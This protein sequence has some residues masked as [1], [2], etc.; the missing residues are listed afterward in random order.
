MR[1]IYFLLFGLF[2]SFFFDPV[3]KAQTA[4]VYTFSVSTGALDPMTGSTILI[5][6]GTDDAT[7]FL[8]DIGFTF[9][10]ENIGYTQFSVSPDGFLKLGSSAAVPQITNNITTATNV[11]KLFLFWDDIATGNNGSVRSLISG[12]APNRI[13]IV[14]W[15]VTIPRNTTGAANSTMQ[16]WLY[17]SSGKIEFRYGAG[18]GPASSA[19]IGISGVVSTNYISVTTPAN[20]ASTS[21]ANNSN[22]LWPGSGV[23]YTFSP[24]GPCTG[25]P[26]GGTTV[27]PSGTVCPGIN[28]L[29]VTGSTFGAGLTYQWESSIDNI[30]WSPIAGE[31]NQSLT[32]IIT[33]DTY[34][35]RRIIC[36]AEEAYSS[37]LLV[38]VS[39]SVLTLPIS[40]GFNT[41]GTAIFPNCWTQQYVIGTSNI[42]FQT[43]STNPT[44][45]P[46]EGTRYVYWNSF[47]F[48][49][50]NETRLVSPAIVTTGA[51]NLEVQFYWYN[52][53]STSYNSGAYLL[54]GV[55]VQ[56][57]LDGSTWSD[58]GAFIP[59]YD[60][61]IPGGTREWKLKKVN[62]PAA[63]INQPL[64][65]VGFK[66]HSSFGDNCSLDAVKIQT[67][68]PVTLSQPGPASQNVCIGSTATFT[69][70]ATGE[71]ITYQWRKG[72]VNLTNGGDI[73][74]AT[75]ST[76][77]IAN[78]DNTDVGNYDVVITSTCGT[79]IISTPAT[80]GVV[81]PP[82]I[83]SQ[84]QNQLLC[85]GSNATFTI[86]ATEPGLTYQWRKDGVNLTNGGNIAGVTSATLTIN[87]VTTN[88]VGSYDVLVT[89]GCSLPSAAA[90]LTLLGIPTITTQPVN[91][92]VCLGSNATLTVVATGDALTYQWRKGGVNLLNGGNI[93]GAT[94]T[95]L[96]I[97]ST[98]AND[99][100]TYDVVISGTCSPSKTSNQVTLAI[101]N[102]ISFTTQPQNR[103]A[104][105]NG[106]VTFTAAATGT[107]TTTQWQV[108]ANGGTTWTDIGGATTTTLTL[109]N[110]QP[111]Q[112]GY[113]YRL[114]LSNA[115]CGAVNSNAATLTVNP[116]P[117]VSLGLSPAGQT[118]L[119]PGMLTTL[120]VASSPAGVSYQWF[121]NGVAQTSITGSSYAV[122]AYHLGTYTVRVTDVN[123]CVSTTSGVTFTALPTS[124]L[125]IYP[126]PTSGAY[127]VTY[128]MPQANTPVTLVVIDMMGRRIVERHEVTTTPYTRFDFSNSKLAAGVYIIEFRNPGGDRLAAGQLVVAR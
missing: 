83:T 117:T 63:A 95:T 119:R 120:T 58:A 94:S 19:S 70:S 36:S 113:R 28:T 53:N 5:N 56:Y 59:R 42:S 25:A 84:P 69:L 46:Y 81:A 96:T 66:F 52:E 118:Q 74:G 29:S 82:T 80:L 39:G 10:Y 50:G 89:G 6:S 47:S 91:Q 65:F 78:V 21:T 109:T 93:T 40:E 68:C 128:Y 87:A 55:Q 13:L 67:A 30:N 38:D 110:V 103:T 126:N 34:F 106:S 14:Q 108:S 116:L 92:F 20:T 107:I 79:V 104:C 125:F 122:D 11:P 37:S 3:L 43:S 75:S 86:V 45:T 8:Q 44:T 15:F 127:Y 98:T 35:R 76:L 22:T 57:S 54:E 64:I 26:T 27:G 2:L 99:A 32:T 114:V 17:E 121:I 85:P 100:G 7:S 1:K 90:T 124:Q 71:G 77:T 112:N 97:N 61:T 123:G 88:N 51:P 4:N 111:S 60:P 102:L 33:S 115:G 31:T 48:S 73:A 72:G 101:Q 12:S 18:G 24:P 9:N 62:L 23:M 41:S 49:N 16:A 105:Q